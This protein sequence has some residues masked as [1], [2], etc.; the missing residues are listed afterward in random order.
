MGTSEG[1][2]DNG[3][4]RNQDARVRTHL[5]NERTF[6]AWLRTSL[7]AM[8]LGLA[9]A[10]F[11]TS[12]LGLGVQFPVT[13]ALAVTLVG[14]GLVIVG[15]GLREYL[16]NRAKIREGNFEPASTVAIAGALVFALAGVLALAFVLLVDS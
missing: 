4:V 9:A 6:L 8:T 16:V 5:A 15:I 7:T 13:R 3:E 11:L 14:G 12:D 2:Q 1:N 10:E